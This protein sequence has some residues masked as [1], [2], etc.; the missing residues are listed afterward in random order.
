VVELMGTGSPDLFVVASAGSI[1][2]AAE[3]P[4]VRQP[5][6]VAME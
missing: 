4:T 3:V 6:G 1:G 5:V 2:G